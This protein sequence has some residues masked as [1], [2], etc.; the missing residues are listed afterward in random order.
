MDDLRE[1]LIKHTGGCAIQEDKRGN[2]WPCGTCVCALLGSVLDEGAPEY[3]EHN[4]PVD[5]INE[6][7]R[8]ILQMRDA[9]TDEKVESTNPDDTPY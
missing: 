3:A 9:S 7:W 5:R 2:L 8:A 6:V 1:L 4:E